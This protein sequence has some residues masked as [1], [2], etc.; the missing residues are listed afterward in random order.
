PSEIQ[1]DLE[2]LVETNNLKNVVNFKGYQSEEAL[3]IALNNAGLLLNT[4]EG[5]AFG[6][7]VLEA[8]NHGVP[9]VAYKVKYGLTEQ[10]E[11]GEN[12]YLVLMEQF[13][14]LLTLLQKLFNQKQI[15]TSFLA[16]L[17]KR[18]KSIAK[19]LFGDSGLMRRLLLIIY[20]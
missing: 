20:S 12:G 17:T 11:N 1:K 19:K 2:K 14:L 9:V 4:S 6:M 10:I 16:L 3:E 18:Q 5:E 13:K 8:L 7:N 15:G